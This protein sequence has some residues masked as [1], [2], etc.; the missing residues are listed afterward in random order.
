MIRTL[1][2]DDDAE[3]RGYL[4]SLLA[5]AHPEVEVIG[6]AFNISEAQHLIAELKPALVFL[7][8][9]MPGGSG[10]D[11]LRELKRWDFEVIFVTGFQRY[12][13]QAIRFSALD[14]LPKPAQPDELAFALERYTERHGA[15]M[16]RAK[17]QEQFLTNIAQPQ[18]EGFRLSI[19]HGDRTFF[20]APTEVERCMAD[21]NYT[22]VHLVHDRRF[23]L[24]RTLKEFEEMLTPF[25]FL[26]LNRSALVRKDTIVRLHDGHAELKDGEKLEVSRRRWPELKRTWAA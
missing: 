13:I 16:D 22:W 12:A 9:E 5:D 6:E 24:A 26:R 14:Y 2:V 15:S 17:L 25:G 18:V 20:V 21:R 11:L 23:L 8:V 10:F 3:A 1:I 7:D 4:R 19:P